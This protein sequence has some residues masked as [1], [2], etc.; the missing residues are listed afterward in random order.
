[1][2]RP[3]QHVQHKPEDP[4]IKLLRSMGIKWNG[5]QIT[6]LLRQAKDKYETDIPLA[7]EISHLVSFFN[8]MILFAGKEDHFYFKFDIT[9]RW[10]HIPRKDSRRIDIPEEIA[11]KVLGEARALLDTK[12]NRLTDMLGLDKRTIRR[13]KK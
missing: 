1:M 8:E 9:F 3:K 5:E 10:W 13:N 12:C 11:W 4:V 7:Q 6:A 2:D